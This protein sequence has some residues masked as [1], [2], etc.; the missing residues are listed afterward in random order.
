MLKSFPVTWIVDQDH[1]VTRLG[2]N[3]DSQAQDSDVCHGKNCGRTDK[4]APVGGAKVH[5][6]EL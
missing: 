6:D 2:A 4:S 1:K 3:E 5:S